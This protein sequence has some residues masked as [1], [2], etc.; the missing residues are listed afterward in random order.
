MEANARGAYGAVVFAPGRRA[1]A[2]QSGLARA[3]ETAS[4][5]T[6]S[7]WRRPKLADDPGAV[8]K[9]ERQLKAARTRIQT[10]SR[11]C[12]VLEARARANWALQAI[13]RREGPRSAKP[14]PSWNLEGGRRGC[15]PP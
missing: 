13:G 1:D 5:R 9:L 8:A 2:H 10:L 12:L 15:L 3:D 7:H 14:G 6:G 11:S 4:I